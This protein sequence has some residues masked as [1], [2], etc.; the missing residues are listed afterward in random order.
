MFRQFLRLIAI[1]ALAWFARTSVF[2]DLEMEQ[3][4][5]GFPGSE[6]KSGDKRLTKQKMLIKGDKLKM[7][8][9][10]EPLVCIVRLDKSV[11][12][13]INDKEKT[14]VERHLSYFEKLRKDRAAQRSQEIRQLNALQDQRAREENAR[15]LGYRLREDGTIDETITAQIEKPGEKKNVADY[16]CEHVIVKENDRVIFDLWV[17]DKLQVSESLMKFYEELG[18][19]SKQVLEK[20]REIKGFPLEMKMELDVGAVSFRVEGQVSKIDEAAQIADREFDLPEGSKKLKEISG[21]GEKELGE[22]PCV[23]CGKKVNMQDEKSVFRYVHKGVTYILCSKEH[24]R[25]F[26]RLLVAHGGKTDFLQKPQQANPEEQKP[27]QKKPEEQK[28]EE[29]K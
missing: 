5:N 6:R 24:M 25:E 4:T 3:V 27:E 21:E 8:N 29:K 19:F 23:I 2:A 26:T 1:S 10:E 18:A 28:P 20:V 12:W 17:A 22:V 14:Y 11:I 7:V 13:E 15:K 9:L 16:E